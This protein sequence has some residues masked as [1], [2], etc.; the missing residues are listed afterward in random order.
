MSPLGVVATDAPRRQPVKI[1]IASSRESIPL[2]REIEVWLAE[3]GHEPVPWD[4]PGLFM[5]SEQTFKILTELSRNVEAAVFIF[6]EDDRVWYRGDTV[7]QPRDNVLIEY[8]LF[9]G[10]LGP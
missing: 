2:V 4:K 8:G 10:Q 1:F 7:P 3:Q 5:P 9:A 6:G